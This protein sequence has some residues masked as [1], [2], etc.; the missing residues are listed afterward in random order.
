[1]ANSHGFPSG[2]GLAFLRAMERRQRVETETCSPVTVL[3]KTYRGSELVRAEV[4]HHGKRK[5]WRLCPYRHDP[6][7]SLAYMSS[8][9][10]A[11]YIHAHGQVGFYDAWSDGARSERTISR[12][13]WVAEC[14]EDMRRDAE[15]LPQRTGRTRRGRSCSAPEPPGDVR[16]LNNEAHAL[17]QAGRL[18][19]ASV[20]VARARAALEARGELVVDQA[21]LANVQDWYFMLQ[22]ELEIGWRK[23]RYAELCEDAARAYVL[24]NALLLLTSRFDPAD[25][26][27]ARI[28][29]E[30]FVYSYGLWA[31]LSYQTRTGHFDEAERL[32]ASE[33][34]DEGR[35]KLRLVARRDQTEHALLAGLAVF[36]EN[37]ARAAAIARARPVFEAVVALVGEPETGVLAHQLACF[38]AFYEEWSAAREMVERAASCGVARAE[39]EVDPDLAPLFSP[40]RAGR[41]R[42]RA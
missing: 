37:P 39:L 4:L 24:E 3:R 6:L 1:M 33:L 13:E 26:K 32:L 25:P 40:A 14:L 28:A 15:R 20:V 21:N 9:G 8:D 29:D 27:R 18:D 5:G 2:L 41:A 38:H 17:V 7:D 10:L 30:R 11:A 34:E 23:Q 31:L 35:M 19:E 12:E 22:R 16:A 42:P 36:V